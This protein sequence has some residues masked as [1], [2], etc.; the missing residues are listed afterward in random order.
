MSPQIIPMSHP[1][2]I[3]NIIWDSDLTAPAP[4]KINANTAETANN[5]VNADMA[6]K[7]NQDKPIFFRS[8]GSYGNS[9]EQLFFNRTN[10]PKTTTLKL[11]K[12]PFTI[13]DN[14]GYDDNVGITAYNNTECINCNVY[15]KIMCTGT[16]ELSCY[17]GYFGNSSMGIKYSDN[18]GNQSWSWGEDSGGTRQITFDTFTETHYITDL[19][20]TAGL[21]SPEYNYSYG[22][23]VKGIK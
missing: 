5:A 14:F 23:S 6:N 16:I 2:K 12:L 19:W 7:L 20:V 13:N 18:V 22:C 21:S 4:Y 15:Q 9:V 3:S 1:N 10:G 8:M 11:K 17:T